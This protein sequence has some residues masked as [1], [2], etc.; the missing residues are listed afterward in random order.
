MPHHGPR[1]GLA[2][3]VQLL[4]QSEV[5]DFRYGA[6]ERDAAR[7]VLALE[8]RGN[9]ASSATVAAHGR[10]RR[11]TLSAGQQHVGRFEI[12]VDDVLIVGR[13][14]GSGQQADDV[15]GVRGRAA[16]CHRAAGQ[17]AAVAVFQREVG[18]AVVLADLV[19][20]HDVRMLQPGDGLRFRYETGAFLRPA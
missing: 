10:L 8:P 2:R 4:G 18:V 16:E 12:A 6:V 13:L 3:F 17:A 14:H 20:L 1:R 19:D 11:F 5:G 9:L 7:P 15:G